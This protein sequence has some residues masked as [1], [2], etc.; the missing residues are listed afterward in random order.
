MSN[1][2]V[3]LAAAGLLAAVTAGVTGSAPIAAQDSRFRLS[4]FMVQQKVVVRVQRAL[5]SQPIEWREK[6]GPKCVPLTGLAGALI[7]KPDAV[8]LVLAGGD[9]VRARLDKDC[10]ALNFYSGFYIKPTRDGKVCADRDAVHSRSGRMCAIEGFK[11]LVA[12]R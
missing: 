11:R 2:P 8:D 1:P 6:K 5:P 10:P 9:R 12:K 7:L 3:F 4:Q